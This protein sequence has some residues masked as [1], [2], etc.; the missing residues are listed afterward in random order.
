MDLFLLAAQIFFSIAHCFRSLKT[1]NL[2]LWFCL[3]LFYCSWPLYLPSCH[4]LLFTLSLFAVQRL[5]AVR[6]RTQ[7]YS[8]KIVSFDLAA[9]SRVPGLQSYQKDCFMLGVEV[10]LLVL[11]I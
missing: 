10:V 3:L 7:C 9:G 1:S 8:F 4:Q 11:V 6:M 2:T 5:L